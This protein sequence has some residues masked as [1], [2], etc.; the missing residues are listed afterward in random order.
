MADKEPEPVSKQAMPEIIGEPGR[1]QMVT[2][3]VNL[4]V[5]KNTP[6]PPGTRR[7]VQHLRYWPGD[8]PRWPG[9]LVTAG[10]AAAVALV[11]GILI[12]RFLLP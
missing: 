3:W 9:R 1:I 4:G 11:A 2:K 12:G 7:R 10:I 8:E 6:R 5:I